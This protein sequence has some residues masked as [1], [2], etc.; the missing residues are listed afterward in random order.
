MR[1]LNKI[2]KGLFV[3]GVGAVVGFGAFAQS[4]DAKRPSL[5]GGCLPGVY[6]L[7]VWDPV[8]CPNGQVYSNDCYAAKA[9]QTGCTPI[10][11]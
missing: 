4:V 10:Y 2:G 8:I 6:C 5:G 3:V 1:R 9:C 7:D 11:Y